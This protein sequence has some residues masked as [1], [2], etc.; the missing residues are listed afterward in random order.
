MLIIKDNKNTFYTCQY[1][2]DRPT[3]EVQQ[4][5]EINIFGCDL[6]YVK[7]VQKYLNIV[8]CDVIDG[9]LKF[10]DSLSDATL[11]DLKT[12]EVYKSKRIS[13]SSESID[14]IS[15][16]VRLQILDECCKIT[17]C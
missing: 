1:E 13:S 16:V 10:F 12:N 6:N 8:I 17:N 2:F 5:S 11:I 9:Q 4:D 3:F 7:T 15:H 14:G